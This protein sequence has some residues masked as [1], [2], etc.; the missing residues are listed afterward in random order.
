MGPSGRGPFLSLLGPLSGIFVAINNICLGDFTIFSKLGA[1][2]YKKNLKRK[3]ALF[4][5]GKKYKL[6]E[7]PFLKE[8]YFLK[9]RYAIII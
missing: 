4:T 2:F 9:E 8:G 7:V 5:K 6:K 1:K 3:Q